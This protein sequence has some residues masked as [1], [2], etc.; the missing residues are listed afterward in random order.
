MWKKADFSL[1]RE[2]YGGNLE[3]NLRCGVALVVAGGGQPLLHKAF[4]DFSK[5]LAIFVR[6]SYCR[7][8]TG[9]NATKCILP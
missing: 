8:F 5:L 1:S 4:C 6:V 7:E 3:T 9:Y 2:I